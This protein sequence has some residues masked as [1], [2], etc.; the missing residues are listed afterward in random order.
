MQQEASY[1]ANAL[2]KRDVFVYSNAGGFRL[3]ANSPFAKINGLEAAIQNWSP[4]E[5]HA[6]NRSPSCLS[7]SYSN[8]W[9][10]VDQKRQAPSI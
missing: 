2:P 5:I 3:N 6:P 8:L 1:S 4:P 10:V 9:F 7:T